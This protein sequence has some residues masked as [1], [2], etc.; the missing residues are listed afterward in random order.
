MSCPGLVCHLLSPRVPHNVVLFRN[1]GVHERTHTLLRQK[2]IRRDN[3]LVSKARGN[4]CA[5]TSS[6]LGQNILA[7]TIMVAVGRQIVF[8]VCEVI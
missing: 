6:L 7:Y 1:N 2:N 8:M 3:S 4:L 5:L